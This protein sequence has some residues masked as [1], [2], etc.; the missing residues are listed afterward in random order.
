MNTF[1]YWITGLIKIFQQWILSQL[2]ACVLITKTSTKTPSKWI[3]EGDINIK[4]LIKP[5]IQLFLEQ[6]LCLRRPREKRRWQERRWWKS[7]SKT[8][9]ISARQFRGCLK[10]CALLTLMMRRHSKLRVDSKSKS[11]I[12]VQIVAPEETDQR[13]KIPPQSW[14]LGRENYFKFYYFI[15]EKPNNLSWS[16]MVPNGPERPISGQKWPKIPL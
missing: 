1:I 13:E 4:S 6:C 3:L 16:G 7:W 2:Q 12:W 14:A 11:H 5:K 15:I 8:R 10:S 9:M